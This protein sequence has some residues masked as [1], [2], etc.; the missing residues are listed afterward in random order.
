MAQVTLTFSG[1][2]PNSSLQVGDTAYYTNPQSS[3]GF[4]VENNEDNLI[5][6]GVVTSITYSSPL[7]TIV[8]EIDVTTVPPP[9]NSYIFFSKDRS[10]NIASITG[11]FGEVNYI[12]NSTNQAEMFTTTCDVSVSSK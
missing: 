6:I 3:S 5:T 2:A 10:A 9:S 1:I 12:N 11:Y 4:L 8:C 7:L